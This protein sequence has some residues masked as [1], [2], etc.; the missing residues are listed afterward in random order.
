MI[1]REGEP[2]VVSL[3]R[4]AIAEEAARMS[5]S[6][7]VDSSKLRSW[8]IL[9]RLRGDIERGEGIRGRLRVA[10]KPVVGMEKVGDWILRVERRGTGEVMISAKIET[11]LVASSSGFI[12][13]AIYGRAG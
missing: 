12:M 2:R 6:S 3:A 11:A 9:W 10:D 4:L 1:E 13:K 5:A 7:L 8:E